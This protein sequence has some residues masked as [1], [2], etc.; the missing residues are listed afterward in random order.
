MKIYAVFESDPWNTISSFAFKKL[1]TSKQRT[2]AF[3]DENKQEFQ[4]ENPDGWI[5]H[6]AEYNGDDE[7]LDENVL[8]DFEDIETVK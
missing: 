8:R 5:L 4:D 1:D 2:K 3:F 6:F 7:G